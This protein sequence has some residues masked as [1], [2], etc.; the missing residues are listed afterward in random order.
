MSPQY[1]APGVYVEEVSFR[2][3]PIARLPHGIPIFVG[4]TERAERDGEDRTWKPT[5]LGSLKAFRAVFGR[6]A[7]GRRREHLLHE[8]VSLFVQNGG[9]DFWILSMGGL[10]KT[11]STGLYSRALD[12]LLSCDEPDL[13]VMPEVVR[14][15]IDAYPVH[16]DALEHCADH[17]RRLYLLDLEE[18]RARSRRFGWSH[19]V[20]ELRARL[21]V[22]ESWA[23]FGAAY[24]PWL[25][26]PGGGR[27]PPSGAVAGVIASTDRSRGVWKAPAGVSLSGVSGLTTR[28]DHGMQGGLNVDPS[29]GYSVNAIREFVGRGILVWG[30]RTLAGNDNEWRYVPVQRMVSWIEA[31]IERS[32][33]WVVFEPND[34][35]LWSQVRSLIDQ[36]LMGLWRDGALAGAMARDAWFVQVGLGRTM[37]ALDVQNGILRVLIGVAPV[38]PAE[39]VLVKLS[40]RLRLP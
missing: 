11:L 15:G 30:S 28:I 20:A 5:R 34:E 25:R 2:L 29:T 18:K 23:R 8:A 13:L 7:G 35:P 39:F 31:S 33:E 24:T 1:L 40:F 17:G 4:L 22:S 21:G 9:G 14:L 10:Q 16:R 19:G 37:T 26:L 12:E 27:V 6:G 32:L 3:V 36:F 38:K